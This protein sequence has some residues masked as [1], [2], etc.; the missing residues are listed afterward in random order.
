MD[1]WVGLWVS[2]RLSEQETESGNGC[3]KR[4]MRLK[5]APLLHALNSCGS[6]ASIA[7]CKTSAVSVG[8]VWGAQ[9]D[10]AWFQPVRHAVPEVPA[11]SLAQA[12]SAEHHDGF[13][14]H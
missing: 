1:G 13:E 7:D 5:P 3:H 11:L 14:H 8:H 10:V 2:E 4:H 12:Q 9:H 6:T